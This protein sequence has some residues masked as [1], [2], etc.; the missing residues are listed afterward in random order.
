MNN[1]AFVF[2]FDFDKE[3][4]LNLWH[5]KYVHN[6]ETYDD[7]RIDDYIK[8][9]E[10]I[11]QYGHWSKD[12]WKIAHA[13]ADE[14][15]TD[16]CNKLDINAKPRFYTL[17]ANE[18]LPHHVDNDTECAINFI[19]SDEAAPITFQETGNTYYYKT[20][21]LNTSLWHGVWN[22]PNDRIL[23][24]LSIFDQPYEAV[25]EKLERIL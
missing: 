23:L 8:R 18:V 3:K 4:L 6:L 1:E 12:V 13:E 17:K 25:K 7:P 22:G 24:K 2:D 20:A 10:F 9:P 15:I 14:Y 16:L 11:A 5:S 19:L 21:L